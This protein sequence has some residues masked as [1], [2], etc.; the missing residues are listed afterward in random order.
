MVK[1]YIKNSL[2]K[3]KQKRHWQKKNEKKKKGF[4]IALERE[5]I[6]VENRISVEKTDLTNPFKG[7]VIKTFSKHPFISSLSPYQSI[8]EPR[9]IETRK[10]HIKV[11]TPMHHQQTRKQIL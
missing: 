1:I 2:P 5:K 6:E 10:K 8:S 9:K 3:L 4:L 7:I 11:Q